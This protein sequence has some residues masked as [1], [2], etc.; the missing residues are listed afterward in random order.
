VERGTLKTPLGNAT[1][2]RTARRWTDGLGKSLGPTGH[3]MQHPTGH[4]TTGAA[5]P[6]RNAAPKTGCPVRKPLASAAAKNVLRP[7]HLGTVNEAVVLKK[8]P[9]T[10]P[11]R[12]NASGVKNLV[13]NGRRPAAKDL[14]ALNEPLNIPFWMLSISAQHV[15]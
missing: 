11:R 8:S 3:A 5:P 12:Q 10:P 1:A 15:Y 14:R 4:A 2:T 7:S 6:G 13:R 9:A